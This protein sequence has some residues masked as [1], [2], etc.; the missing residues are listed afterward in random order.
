MKF[1]QL[2]KMAS[3]FEKQ[4]SLE[5]DMAKRI[6]LSVIPALVTPGH[7]ALSGGTPDE[8]VLTLATEGARDVIHYGTKSCVEEMSHY[9][10]GDPGGEY[11]KITERTN[12]ASNA[13]RIQDYEASIQACIDGFADYPAWASS[14][15]GAKWEKIGR[16]ILKLIEL[17]EAVEQESALDA[18][19]APDKHQKVYQLKQEIVTY[20]NVFDG[21]VHNNGS[22]FEKMVRH[23]LNDEKKAHERS[24]SDEEFTDT[25]GKRLQRVKYMMD[26]KELNNPLDVYRGIEHTLESG[27]HK[28]LLKDWLT[29]ARNHPDYRNSNE[30][31]VRQEL[32]KVKI[33]KTLIGHMEAPMAAAEVL[34]HIKQI[35]VSQKDHLSSDL[36]YLNL[37]RTTFAKHI[38]DEYNRVVYSCSSMNGDISYM[39]FEPLALPGEKDY[40]TKQRIGGKLQ[41]EILSIRDAA[42]TQGELAHES[43]KKGDI[44]TTIGALE[45][46]V[47]FV[48]SL[49][50]FVRSI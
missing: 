22:I 19:T 26:L 25:F 47:N 10:N 20:L 42:E 11:G 50:N 33:K 12:Q 16:T 4:A 39:N 46:I 24:A 15:G 27:G 45:Q 3:T 6:M 13:F 49:D 41:S 34:N 28:P 35:L 40:Q 21:L 18:A 7:L 48:G 14:Y 8:H 23:E 29:K 37:L 31:A 1:V 30:E 17:R 36:K 5:T 9:G 44:D 38:N 43:M 32:A 2:M